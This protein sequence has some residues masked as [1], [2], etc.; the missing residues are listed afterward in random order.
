MDLV[1]GML[2]DHLRAHF[3][4]EFQVTRICPPLQR[5]FGTLPMVGETSPARNADRLLNRFYIY[6]RLLRK[7]ETEFDLFHVIDHTYGH[8]VHELPQARTVVTCHDLDAFRCL[9]EPQREPRSELFRHMSRRILSGVS[10]AARVTCD[11]NTVRQEILTHGLLPPHRLTVIPNGV[12]P[13]C[14]SIPC[15]NP[16]TEIENLLG[17]A[18]GDGT[19]ILNVGSTVPRKRME[20]LIRVFAKIRAAIPQARLI[21][22]G[23]PFSP[24]QASL[25]AELDVTDSIVV[26]P[27]LE[28][29]ALAAVYRRA[30]VVL[31]PSAREGFGLPIVEAMACGTPV[32]ASDLPIM[33]E[34]GAE[35]AFYCS[36]DDVEAWSATTL[37]LLSKRNTPGEWKAIRAAGIR[38]AAQF[39]W[40]L[41]AARTAQI[42]RELM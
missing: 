26:L 12:H 8:L 4:S 38:H 39:S 10:Q 35:A 30:S 5:R 18:G 3:A 22:A 41:Y 2:F 42:Y 40:P 27:F 16:D 29:D 13:S 9:L 15:P 33:R 24:S 21:R 19:E 17:P 37:N 36:V 7:L 23:G 28:R 6:P 11:S 25:A 14:T 34:T 32:V 1:A 20:I 31:Q